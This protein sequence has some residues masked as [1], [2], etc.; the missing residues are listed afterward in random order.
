MKTRR[1]DGEADE[2]EGTRCKNCGMEGA[3]LARQD[4]GRRLEM[5]VRVASG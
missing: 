2:A 5:A 1:G 4:G 3:E